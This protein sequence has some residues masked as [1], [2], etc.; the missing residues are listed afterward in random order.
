MTFKKSNEKT[1]ICIGINNSISLLESNR[2]SIMSVDIME[3]S[4]A[5]KEKKIIGSKYFNHISILK[6]TDFHNLY[7]GKRTQGIVVKFKGKLTLD[8]LPRYDYPGDIC[9]L[10]L[11]RIEDPQNLGQIIRT[12]ECAGI[13]GIVIPRHNSTTVTETVIQVSQGAF[14]NI[15]I[16]EITNLNQL[17]LKLKK[18]GFWIIGIENSVD[19]KQWHEINYRDKTVIVVG[20]EGYGIRKKILENCDFVSTIPMQGKSSSLNVSATVSAILF[21]RLRQ[22][23]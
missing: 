19:A 9:I 20:S 4:L 16:Y 11:D 5:H 18:N 17:F 21:E 8:S 22:I 6:K 2:F 7:P 15:P 1:H 10:A 12:A 14:V 23:Q 13:D 3:G